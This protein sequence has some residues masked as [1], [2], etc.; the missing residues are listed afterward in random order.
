[1]RV[2][3]LQAPSQPR[4]VGQLLRHLELT[5]TAASLALLAGGGWM[6]RVDR[7][8]GGSRLLFLTGSVCFVQG[9]VL[10]VV[11]SKQRSA[12]DQTLVEV[13]TMLQDVVN[14]Q[15]VVIQMADQINRRKPGAVPEAAVERSVG[16]IYEAIASLSH[17]SLHAWSLKYRQAKDRYR[18]PPLMEKAG[19]SE[20]AAEQG[21][22]TEPSV[23][24]HAELPHEPS[25]EPSSSTVSSDVP[26]SDVRVTDAPEDEPAQATL[27]SL[28]VPERK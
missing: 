4:A 27:K 19:P 16:V 12:R 22:V 2:V 17:E 9:L 20:D 25:G 8:G 28:R 21:P 23:S 26:Q 13:Q 24:K 11:R 15:L 3:S 18:V 14:N 5:V 10:W 7:A 1:M 6:L